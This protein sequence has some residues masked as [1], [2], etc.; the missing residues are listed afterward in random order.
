[1]S[2]IAAVLAVGMTTFGAQLPAPQAQPGATSSTPQQITVTGCVQN[3]SDYRPAHDAG[4]GGVAGTGVGAGNE[5]VLIDV[6]ASTGTTDARPTGE[7]PAG[8][9]VISKDLKAPRIRSHV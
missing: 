3:E 2:G 4:R 8:V 7:P 5:F 1:M 9:D 6:T